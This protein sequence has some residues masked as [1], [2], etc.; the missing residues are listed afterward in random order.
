M[1]IHTHKKALSRNRRFIYYMCIVLVACMY[2]PAKA[3]FN[4]GEIEKTTNTVGLPQQKRAVSG[5]VTDEK[6]ETVIGANVSVKGT[7]I[8][9]I[10]D[11][12]GNY[13]LEVSS[14]DILVVSYIGYIP[15]EI[16][17]TNQ[18]RLDVKLQESLQA[19][20]EVVVIGYGSMRKQDLTGSISSMRT[21]KYED[22][23]PKNIQ[24]L[25]RGNVAG[26]NI[27]LSTNA[28]G[29]G[30][31]QVRGKR[32]LKANASPLLVLDG[33]IYNGTLEDLNPDDIESIDVLKD[34]SSSAV[35]GAKSANGV[36]I[37]NTRKGSTEKP[38]INLNMGLGIATLFRSADVY[39][40]DEFI[41]WRSDVLRSINRNAPAYVFTDPRKLPAGVTVEDWKAYDG[42]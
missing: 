15:Q 10:T 7:T 6:G 23:K 8:G 2:I 29:G 39:G 36:V 25:L 1:N 5:T 40:P 22:E 17:V 41:D 33:V 37:I 24:D 27:G 14:G 35:Y 38:T 16:P 13:S 28:K 26:L 32:T 4:K 34:A 31:L 3:S 20:D 21:S 9:T 11:I 12:D 42:S 19:L 18:S 30:D